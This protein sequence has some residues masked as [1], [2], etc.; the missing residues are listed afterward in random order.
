MSFIAFRY[1]FLHIV[2]LIAILIYS[3][4]LSNRKT[5]YWKTAII[6]ILLFALEEGLR[7]GRDGDWW[8][9]RDTYYLLANGYDV[10]N[11]LLF[12]FF[13]KFLSSIGLDYSFAV[14]FASALFIYSLFFLL[15]D[16]RK[17]L[18]FALPLFVI[19]LS[20]LAIQLIRWFMGLS[21]CFIALRFLLDGAFKKAY[22]FLGLS[23]FIHTFTGVLFVPCFILFHFY[24]TK[25]LLKP[26]KVIL[27]SIVLVIFANLSFMEH[28]FSL[29]SIFGDSSRYGG[30]VEHADEWFATSGS[31]DYQRK[32]TFSYL[33]VML[34]FYI[35]L[36]YFYKIKDAIPYSY[37]IINILIINIMLRSISSGSEIVQ[38]I[39]TI[40]DFG[41]LFA[42]AMV[43][44][45]WRKFKNQLLLM[46]V[47]A[48]FLFK[49]YVFIKPYKSDLLMMYVWDSNK[50]DDYGK[51]Y[52]LFNNEK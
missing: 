3:R 24:S 51:A 21:V 47:I 2:V 13:W 31:A 16:S 35:I 4:K 19:W 7:W 29:L 5:S 36:Y 33:A 28:F 42:S 41:F 25:E 23:F 27:L 20:P 17:V 34:P 40:Y 15:K 49:T 46:V 30:Y 11:E 10:N 1:I 50:I 9:Y 14:F 6:P 8:G 18:A 48:T 26:Q 32:S 12:K 22:I 39:A 37:L 43:L 44:Y 38:R 52:I 45:R